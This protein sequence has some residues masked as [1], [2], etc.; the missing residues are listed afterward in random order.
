MQLEAVRRRHAGAREI[1]RVD[2]GAVLA[3]VD[4]K[5][6]APHWQSP[7]GE[8]EAAVARGAG[9]VRRCCVVLSGS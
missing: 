2:G 5:A 7:G 6:V 1:E 8:V 9:G 3:G 4:D